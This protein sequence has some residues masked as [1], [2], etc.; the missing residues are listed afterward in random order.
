MQIYVP[1]V[2]LQFLN[3]ES[4]IYIDLELCDSYGTT[5]LLECA[6]RGQI[7]LVKRLIEKGAN[8]YACD[9]NRSN[10][11]ATACDC[12]NTD[13]V[14][15]MLNVFKPSEEEFIFQKSYEIKF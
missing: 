7:K 2:A 5:I 13:I 8:I 1:Y 11:L 15:L 9:H 14:L 6:Q 12:K 3:E 10:I 4:N